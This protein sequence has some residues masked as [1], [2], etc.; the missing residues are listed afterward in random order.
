[1]AVKPRILLVDDEKDLCQI[2]SLFFSHNGFEVCTAFTGQEAQDCVQSQAIDLTVLDLNLAGQDGLDV[3]AFIK[4]RPTSHPVIIYTGL[5]MDEHLVKRCLA[6][7]ADGFVHKTAGL[8]ALLKEARKFF[9]E[10]AAR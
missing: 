7:R 8:G 3:L 6:G 10:S 5:D 2:L 1:M 9:P 4:N